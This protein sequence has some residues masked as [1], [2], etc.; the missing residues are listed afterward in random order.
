MLEPEM[1]PKMALATIMAEAKLPGR[2]PKIFSPPMKR[3]RTVPVVEYKV[4]IKIKSGM[5]VRVKE[6]IISKAARA[7]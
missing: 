6:F 3:A 7:K 1:A 4:P 5:A 2:F